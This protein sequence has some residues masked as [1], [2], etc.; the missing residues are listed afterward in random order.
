MRRAAVRRWAAR[1]G[2]AAA[3]VHVAGI[4]AVAGQQAFRR[5]E[6]ARIYRHEPFGEAQ[7]RLLGAGYVAALRRVRAEVPEDATIYLIDGEPKPAGA[8]YFAL[9]YLAPRRVVYCGSPARE[10]PKLVLSRLP[11]DARW[12][13]VARQVGA[14]LELVAAA[15]L[16]PRR[17][18]RGR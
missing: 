5:L 12:V 14:P 10:S 17:H 2:V 6:I 16:R 9:H 15:E 11:A 8:A 7:S 3:V 18:R 13:V 1:L 4:A